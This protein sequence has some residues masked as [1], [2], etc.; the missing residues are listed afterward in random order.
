MTISAKPLPTANSKFARDAWLRALERTATI[1]Q[2][3][4]TLPVL[5]NRLARQFDAAPALVS[6]EA[7][8]SYQDLANRCNQYARWGLARGF[9]AGELVAEGTPTGIKARQS[10]HLLEFVVDQPQRAADLLKNDTAR[11]RVSLFGERLHVITEENPALAIEQ[12][13]K[14]LAENGIDVI[15][16]R[17]GR[18]SLEDVFIAIVE[19]A[20]LQGKV[21]TED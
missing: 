2:R 5:I 21:V 14:R 3:G 6:A 18:F 12:T 4:V 20:R 13:R 7:T 1:F 9:E 19:Q 17:E 16:A 11:W 15:S 8:L 10:G